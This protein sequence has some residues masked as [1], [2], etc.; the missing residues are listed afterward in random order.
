MSQVEKVTV[1]F[2]M[3]PANIY[4]FKS[5]NKKTRKWSEICS[6]LIK[7]TYFSPFPSVSIVHFE[8]MNNFRAVFNVKS[9]FDSV[10]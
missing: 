6:K 4:L 5:I 9:K 1:N 7:D 10:K 3:I 2:D 8:R